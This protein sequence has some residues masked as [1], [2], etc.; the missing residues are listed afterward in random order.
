MGIFLQL[1]LIEMLEFDST[2]MFNNNL[3][4][5]LL[6]LLLGI[7]IGYIL[8]NISFYWNVNHYDLQF[9]NNYVVYLLA[10]TFLI[11]IIEQWLFL[12]QRIRWFQKMS[13][14]S[15]IKFDFTF[16]YITIY[17][18]SMVIAFIAALCFMLINSSYLDWVILS[19]ISQIL[20]SYLLFKIPLVFLTTEEPVLLIVL[21]S[22]GITLFRK[23][24]DEKINF[25]EQLLGAY[26]NAIDILGSNVISNSGS[27]SSI[28]FQD[29]FNLIIKEVSVSTST[30]QFCYI[31]KGISYYA[32]QRLTQLV[33]LLS[34]NE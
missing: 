28:K 18:S 19:I 17:V 27:V 25:S 29:K 12:A 13:Q 26:L 3:F 21:S 8:I 1:M 10:M 14:N 32:S 4:K 6:N 23:R 15:T 7:N 20:L 34:K 5:R 30:I 31:Y 33:R 2:L 22:T 16:H 11:F 9:S 24:F